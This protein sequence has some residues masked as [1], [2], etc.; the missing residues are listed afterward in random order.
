LQGKNSENRL[1]NQW[2]GESQLAKVKAANKAVEYATA[3]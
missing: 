1:H 3:A 2:F